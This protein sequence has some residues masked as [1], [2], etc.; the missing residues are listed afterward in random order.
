MSSSVPCTQ[1]LINKHLLTIPVRPHSSE[2]QYCHGASHQGH[3]ITKELGSRSAVNIMV[4][5]FLVFCF[6]FAKSST[7]Q[8]RDEGGITLTES[9]HSFP[10]LVILARV[11]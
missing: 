2:A 1:V 10:D 4:F 7:W 5:F 11:P 6:V 8:S 3:F 9:I